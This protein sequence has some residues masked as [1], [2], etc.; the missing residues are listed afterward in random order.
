MPLI[1]RSLRRP[2]RWRL[3]AAGA[4]VVLAA[5]IA[6]AAPGIAS[7]TAATTNSA[8]ADSATAAAT[9]PTIV[10]NPVSMTL[11]SGQFIVDRGTRVIARGAAREVATDLATD[12]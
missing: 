11:G 7:A 10:P 6:A 4:A 1:H 12:L 8:T 3:S 2:P 9:A 5:G